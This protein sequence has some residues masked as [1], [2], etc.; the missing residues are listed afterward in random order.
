[1]TTA[2]KDVFNMLVIINYKLTSINKKKH[3][4][5]LSS[6]CFTIKFHLVW[7][8]ECVWMYVYMIYLVSVE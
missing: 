7:V 8:C 2:I 5:F 3:I 6:S 4:L 1:M